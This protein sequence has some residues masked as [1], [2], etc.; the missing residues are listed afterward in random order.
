MYGGGHV[1]LREILTSKVSKLTK[2]QKK[3]AKYII[4]NYKECIFLTAKEISTNVGV[5]ETS[6]LRL[7]YELG[8]RSFVSM[9]KEMQ[10]D[11]SFNENN[12][13]RIEQNESL[14]KR[15]PLM[16][17]ILESQVQKLSKIYAN[18]DS[19]KLDTIC[20]ILMKKK[21][22][23]IIGYMDSFGIAS[24]LL[25]LFD[26]IRKRVYFSKLAFE[27]EYILEDIDEDSATIVVSFSP[28]Y[29]ATLN[30]AQNVKANGSKIILITDSVVNPFSS[31]VDHSL[32][33]NINTNP[34]AGI[35]DTSPVHSFLYYMV[36]R[37]F[38]KNKEEILE[39]KKTS[40]YSREKFTPE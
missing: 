1:S 32:M 19:Q 26:N 16:V 36:N 6:V 13:S 39:Y 11:I 3:I 20:D 25:H 37:I 8:Y 15:D 14:K 27:N 18:I 5:S 38:E 40:R 22:I 7:S 34:E 35:V 10:L 23:L 12:S 28:H 21:R 2:S 17:S 30:Q 4:N 29:Q 9:K 33:F 24:E 31:I